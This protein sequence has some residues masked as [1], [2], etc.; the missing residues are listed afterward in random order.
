MIINKVF[1]NENK[2][3]KKITDLN[4]KEEQNFSGWLVDFCPE[5][6]L[7]LKF[8]KIND[9]P[10][11]TEKISYWNDNC[12]KNIYF[13]DSLAD[14]LEER[15]S[16]PINL[17]DGNWTEEEILFLLNKSIGSGKKVKEYRENRIPLR[18]Y[19][20][21]GAQYPIKLFLLSNC[22]AG[23]FKK[24][25]G[26]SIHPDVGL[27]CQLTDNKK[28]IRFEDVFAITHFN[29]ELYNETS[30]VPFLLVMSMNLKHSFIK[31]NHYSRQLAMIEAGHIA[32]NIEL[33][34]TAM[35]KKTLPNGGILS[36]YT[37]QFLGIN[38]PQDNII[39]Y[40]VVLG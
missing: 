32:Q 33:V 39:I 25:S 40:G 2:D 29:K 9:L 16:T 22:N 18:N 30:K 15:R 31:Y 8:E 7:N 17:L 38:H 23:F 28:G 1:K 26:Y 34:A 24:N 10:V 5:N 36:D 37:K 3:Y 27:I 11:T 12:K 21:G 19:P 13:N 4:A 14:A 35:G 6:T 20:S